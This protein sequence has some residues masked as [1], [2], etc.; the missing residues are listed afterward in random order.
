[1]VFRGY[2]ST[3]PVAVLRDRQKG[4]GPPIKKSII[5]AD[6][7]TFL[8]VFH[9]ILYHEKLSENFRGIFGGKVSLFFRTFARKNS[10]GNSSG[11]FPAYNSMCYCVSL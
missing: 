7:R 9:D 5:I 10:A 11:N 8:A 1:M 6:L 3:D 2:S 4:Q